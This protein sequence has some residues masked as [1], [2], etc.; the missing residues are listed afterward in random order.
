MLLDRSVDL[1]R[2]SGTSAA[3]TDAAASLTDFSSADKATG[4]NTSGSSASTDTI[5]SPEIGED[6]SSTAHEE[7]PT[8]AIDSGSGCG[9]WE[10]PPEMWSIDTVPPEY[11]GGALFTAAFVQAGLLMLRSKLLTGAGEAIAARVR[12]KALGNLVK[13]VGGTTLRDSQRLLPSKPQLILWLARL[14]VF[15]PVHFLFLDLYEVVRVFSSIFSFDFT[16]ASCVMCIFQ[17]LPRN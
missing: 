16:T 9:A 3:K 15:A 5:G 4:T 10:I 14:L 1:N 12:E 7:L 2:S 8:S 6:S 17:T 13:Q 11:I